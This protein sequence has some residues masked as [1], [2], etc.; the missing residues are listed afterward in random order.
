MCAGVLVIGLLS[1]I[2]PAVIRTD[3]H[4]GLLVLWRGQSGRIRFVNSVTQRP[5]TIKLS[6]GGLFHDFAMETDEATEAYYSHGV[7]PV[8]GALAGEATRSLQFCSMQG[9]DLSL[10][11]YDLH[12]RNGCLEVKLLWTI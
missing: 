4:T 9:I 12:L 3:D 6:V 2:K 11:F 8:N 5:V 7:Y 1:I 10:G